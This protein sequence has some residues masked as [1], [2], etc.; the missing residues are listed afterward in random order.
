MIPCFHPR[1]VIAIA[2]AIGSLHI[3]DVHAAD[4]FADPAFAQRWQRDEQFVPNFWGP[5]SNAE[6]G[7][8]EQYVGSDPCPRIILCHVAPP[9]PSTAQR[10]VE[11][12][13]K[14]RMELTVGPGGAS[15]TAG[16]L[17]RELI[18][19]QLQ[20][21]D[22]DFAQRA[23]AAVPVAGDADNPFPFYRDL[24]SGP[25]VT[26][27]TPA[28]SPVQTLLTP[29]G[30]SVASD[31]AADPATVIAARDAET[32]HVLPRAFVDFRGRV[33]LDAVGLALTEPFWVDVRVGGTPRR[34]LVQAFERRV[35]TYTPSNPVAFQVEFGNVGR[36][37]V[38]WRYTSP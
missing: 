31:V 38:A 16:L 33:G 29:S 4:S 10:L 11:Y 37:Y 27:T 23:P 2:M 13:D 14:G 9:D 6:N 21:G 1:T 28:G 3:A 25:A 26:A 17:V 36:Q 15:V 7:Q 22:S 19:G 30:V 34:V 8:Y 24:A 18:T 32:G 35:L 12:F 5:L 20:L